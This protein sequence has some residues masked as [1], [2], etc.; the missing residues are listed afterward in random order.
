M[1]EMTVENPTPDD[2]KVPESTEKES[3]PQQTEFFNLD[4]NESF[5]QPWNLTDAIRAKRVSEIKQKLT[6]DEYKVPT[7]RLASILTK[8][9]LSTSKLKKTPDSPLD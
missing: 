5:A 3:M 6:A 7:G 2:H 9:F 1:T 8:I 4:S